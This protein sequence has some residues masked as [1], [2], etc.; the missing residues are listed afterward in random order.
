MPTAAAPNRASVIMKG[1]ERLFFSGDISSS[2]RGR[3]GGRFLT[4]AGPAVAGGG[5]GVA[6]AMVGRSEPAPRPRLVQP[7]VPAQ[8]ASNASTSAVQFGYLA[9]GCLASSFG[10]AV[11]TLDP[12]DGVK[13][14]AGGG[15]SQTIW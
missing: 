4:G 3:G 2:S 11:S 15:G 10:K 12:N 13:R 14:C 8:A 6:S 1:T 7:G 9:P 5:G